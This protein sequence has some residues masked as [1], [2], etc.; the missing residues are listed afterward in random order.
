MDGWIKA[1]DLLYICARIHGIN[2]MVR[3]QKGKKKT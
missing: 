3:K 1:K 2:L